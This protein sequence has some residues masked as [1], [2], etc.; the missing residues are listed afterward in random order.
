MCFVWC[1]IYP[2]FLSLLCVL[3]LVCL[4]LLNVGVPL[5]WDGAWSAMYTARSVG[6]SMQPSAVAVGLGSVASAI[7]G[8]TLAVAGTLLLHDFHPL[9]SLF[10]RHFSFHGPPRPKRIQSW[11]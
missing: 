11:P 4:Q 1:P 10:K 8:L 5:P 9:F 3:P 7:V 2:P 6:M